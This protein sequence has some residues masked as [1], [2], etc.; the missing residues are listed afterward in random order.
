MLRPSVFILHSSFESVGRSVGRTMQTKREGMPRCGTAFSCHGTRGNIRHRAVSASRFWMP[1]ITDV[2]TDRSGVKKAQGIW[3]HQLQTP[4]TNQ[5][6]V[7]YTNSELHAPISAQYSTPTPNSTHHA[8]L[9]AQYSTPTPNST[10]KSV[11]STV[12]Q[13]QTPR[14]NQCTVRYT[15]SKLPAPISAQYSTPTPNSTH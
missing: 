12:H 14:T 2:H 1:I 5:C 7:Q 3:L 13:L 9:S 4:C 11:H 15:N 6:T 10:H 8:P